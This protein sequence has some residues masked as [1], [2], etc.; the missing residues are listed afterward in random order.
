MSSTIQLPELFKGKATT[1]KNNEY[2]P[3]KSYVEPF[4]EKM[5]AITNDFRIKVVYPEQM[6]SVKDSLDV[7]FNRV[8]IEAV[9]PEKY[10]IDSHD[11]TIG[12]VYGLDVKKP[13]AKIY[14]G[15]LNRAC[16][17]LC[18]FDSSFL[19]IQEIIPGTPINFKP[20]KSLLEQTNTFATTLQRMKSTYIDREERKLHLGNWIDYSLR[21]GNDYGFG[22]VKLAASTSIDA[23]KSLFIDQDSDYF[24]PEGVDVT[25]FDIFGAFTQTVTDGK[26]LLNKTEKTLL[27]SKM[28]NVLN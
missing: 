20:I 5:S 21:E 24:V 1:I 16:T 28:L 2:F 11:E 19:N 3:T 26:D 17:N 6:T 10:C 22:K 8:L 9:L 27:I 13:I 15:Y 14:R 4:I 7:T 23:Y 18:I 25:M 12:F